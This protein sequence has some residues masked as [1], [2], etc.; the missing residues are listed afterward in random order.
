MMATSQVTLSATSMGHTMPTAND[1]TNS[2]M[3]TTNFTMPRMLSFAVTRPMTTAATMN[4]MLI[5][6]VA[7]LA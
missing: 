5:V 2:T 4:A 7:P 6:A 1:A 3:A